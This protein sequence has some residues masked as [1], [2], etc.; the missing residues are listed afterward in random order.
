MEERIHR[1]S[2]APG[3]PG[4][5]VPTNVAELMAMGPGVIWDMVTR[6][7]NSERIQPVVQVHHLILYQW[8]CRI[9]ASS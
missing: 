8:H 4:N 7:V 6:S 5:A 3:R 1:S 2:Q 9:S